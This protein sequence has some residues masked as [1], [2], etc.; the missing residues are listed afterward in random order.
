MK[1]LVLLLSILLIPSPAAA[2]LQAPFVNLHCVGTGGDIAEWH[3]FG[4]VRRSEL[5]GDRSFVLGAIDITR[6]TAI[7]T[8]DL[9][10]AEVRAIPLEETMTFLEIGRSGDQTF[11]TVFYR[12]LEENFYFFVHSRHTSVAGVPVVS[13]THGFCA[14][15]D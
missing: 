3:G 4:D 8:T 12:T 13:Q 11:T 7:L 2:Q 9:G 5:E 10:T 15:V 14:S 6:G 1:R